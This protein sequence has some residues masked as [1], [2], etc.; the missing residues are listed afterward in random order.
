MGERRSLPLAE[1]PRARQRVRVWAFCS[2]RSVKVSQAVLRPQHFSGA[3]TDDH[4]GRHGVS[5]CH[6]R[7]D[8]PVSNTKVIDSIDLER[9][10][11]TDIESRPIFAV[12]V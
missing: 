2:S 4:A 10:S 1:L 12:Q 7:H 11:T 6:A 9:P 5:S 3:F 8:G